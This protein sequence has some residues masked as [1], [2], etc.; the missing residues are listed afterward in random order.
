VLQGTLALLILKTLTRG[1]MHG[2]GI[3][4]HIQRTRE[5]GI[6]M[7]MGAQ[8]SDILRLALSEGALLVVFGVTAGLVGSFVLTRFL[9]SMLFHVTPADPA[10]FAAV[11]GLLAGVALLACFI[12][13]QRATQ[14]APLVALRYE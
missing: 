13:A 6:R 5:I 10:T 8:R 12:P 4:L 2:Y 11:A 14:V 9:Q 3:T 7:A 1:P